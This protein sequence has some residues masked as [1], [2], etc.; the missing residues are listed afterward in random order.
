MNINATSF[1]SKKLFVIK[2][3]NIL[4]SASYFDGIRV[5]KAP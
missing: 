1:S 5:P 4:K 3:I 2:T